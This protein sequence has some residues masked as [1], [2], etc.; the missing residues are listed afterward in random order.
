MN[1]L[2]TSQSLTNKNLKKREENIKKREKKKYFLNKIAK[3]KL[4]Q[5]KKLKMGI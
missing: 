5:K 3:K 2:Y 4:K 1:I